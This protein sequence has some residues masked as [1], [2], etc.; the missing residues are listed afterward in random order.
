MVSS[1]LGKLEV[2]RHLISGMLWAIAGLGKLDAAAAAPAVATAAAPPMNL[3]RSL[4]T[5]LPPPVGMPRHDGAVAGP[6]AE[7]T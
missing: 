5:S 1:D 7:S 2:S 3:R 6:P 4:M